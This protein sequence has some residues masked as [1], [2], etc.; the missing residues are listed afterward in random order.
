MKLLNMDIFF[1]SKYV[2]TNIFNV[3]I[4]SYYGVDQHQFPDITLD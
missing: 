2:S 3:L 4:I 1:P